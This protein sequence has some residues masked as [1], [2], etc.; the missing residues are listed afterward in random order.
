[1]VKAV[2]KTDNGWWPMLR[3][4]RG[5]WDYEDGDDA[6][7]DKFGFS[8]LPGGYRDD[9]GKISSVCGD[10]K[11]SG[12]YGGGEANWWTSTESGKGR[13]HGWHIGSAR[14]KMSDDDWDEYEKHKADGYKKELGFSVRCVQD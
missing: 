12:A 11:I 10:D 7:T 3:A 13:A 6:G 2:T 1:L 9:D 8:A 14:Y 5:W 4:R